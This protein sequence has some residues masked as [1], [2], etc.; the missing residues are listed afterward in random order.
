MWPHESFPK[1]KRRRR[2]PP[3]DVVMLLLIGALTIGVAVLVFGF[4]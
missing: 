3:F 1:H 2:P 4:K